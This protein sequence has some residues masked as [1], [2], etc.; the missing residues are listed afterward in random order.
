MHVPRQPG[1]QIAGSDKEKKMQIKTNIGCKEGQ[2]TLARR[3]MLPVCRRMFLVGIQLDR[4]LKVLRQRNPHK[5]SNLLSKDF[6]P[7]PRR[8]DMC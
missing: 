8:T 3:G 6:L 4:W 1:V 2:K 7:N 5:K